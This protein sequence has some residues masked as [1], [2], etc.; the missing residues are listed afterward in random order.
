MRFSMFGLIQYLT[1]S[2]MP[3][4]AVNQGH[5]RTGPKKFQRRDG[6]G[7][8]GPDHRHIVV[9]IRMRLLVIVQNLLS[10][11]PGTSSRLGTS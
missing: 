10:S 3:G 1:L 8:L 2:E 6:G 11:S 4:A 9:V 7:V 5:A